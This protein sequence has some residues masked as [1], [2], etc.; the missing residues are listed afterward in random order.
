VQEGLNQRIL[1]VSS[2]ERNFGGLESYR[3]KRLKKKK[4]YSRW[5]FTFFIGKETW[6]TYQP[7]KLMNKSIPDRN[8]YLETIEMSE[9]D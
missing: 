6:T 4:W 5:F 7:S 8:E 9:E 2:H 1:S 3:S